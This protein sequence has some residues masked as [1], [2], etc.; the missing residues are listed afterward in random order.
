MVKFAT[1]SVSVPD[2]QEMEAIAQA[3]AHLK[4]VRYRILLGGYP[5]KVTGMRTGGK[6]AAFALILFFLVG[7]LFYW[8]LLVVWFLGL[9]AYVVV[10]RPNRVQ[11]W[12]Y[13]DGVGIGYKGADAYLQAIALKGLL[14]GVGAEVDGGEPH[15]TPAGRYCP[16][17]GTPNSLEAQYCLSCGIQL[18]AG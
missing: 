2:G 1:L 10:Y 17:C 3:K 7:L 4:A 8:P 16:N 5:W 13:E 14:E 15:Q 6:V 11:V 12:V 9:I 18:H